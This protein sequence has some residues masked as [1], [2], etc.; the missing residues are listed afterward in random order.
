MDS[1]QTS[2]TPALR[3]L[4]GGEPTAEELAAIVLALTPA[5]GPDVQ[6]S[7]GPAP[8]LRAAMLEGVGGRTPT[9]PSDLAVADLRG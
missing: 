6:G 2:P 8:W 4:G 5:G 7:R 3:V 9:S 1:E